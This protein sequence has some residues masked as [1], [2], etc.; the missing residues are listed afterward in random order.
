MVWESIGGDVFDILFKNLAIKGR[1]VIIGAISKYA[2]GSFG[3]DAS[4]GLTT[5][6]K[7]YI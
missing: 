6:V 3:Q 5:K 1:M 2:D 7:I 4:K